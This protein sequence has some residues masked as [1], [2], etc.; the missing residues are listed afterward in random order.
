VEIACSL[1][2][3]LPVWY[4]NTDMDRVKTIGTITKAIRNIIPGAKNLSG[5]E[6]FVR[7]A[8]ATIRI[9][10]ARKIAMLVSPVPKADNIR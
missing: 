2:S 6:M 4:L 5:I 7:Y 9:Q 10:T 1:E 3:I 8:K